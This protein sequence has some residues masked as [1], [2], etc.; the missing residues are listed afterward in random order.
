[1]KNMFFLLL[2]LAAFASCKN[3]PGTEKEDGTVAEQTDTTDVNAGLSI[4]P[5]ELPDPCTIIS[6]EELG[7]LFGID[8]KS[9]LTNKADLKGSQ[10]FSE[11]CYHSWDKKGEQMGMIVQ[12][13]KNPLHGEFNEWASTYIGVLVDNGEMGYPDNKANKYTRLEGLGV[14][15]AY[16]VEL[17]KIYFRK[18]DEIIVGLFFRNVSQQKDIANLGK[19]AGELI[20]SKM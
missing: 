3:E 18:N 8:P 2:V 17:G 1:M 7:Q 13:M 14:E 20:L 9:V 19:K 6:A 5:V 15:A 16:S 4:S 12:F 10:G 11:S